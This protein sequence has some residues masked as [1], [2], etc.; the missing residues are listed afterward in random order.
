MAKVHPNKELP[1]IVLEDEDDIDLVAQAFNLLDPVTCAYCQTTLDR[2]SLGGVMP[3]SGAYVVLC[4][5]PI[6]MIE[7]ITDLEDED[8]E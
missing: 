1:L 7:Y 8:D 2:S 4:D 3:L 5:N 6:C